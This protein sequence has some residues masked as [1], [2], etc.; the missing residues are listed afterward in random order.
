MQNTPTPPVSIADVDATR[1]L[2]RHRIAPHFM[3]HPEERVLALADK[4]L[5]EWATSLPQSSAEKIRERRYLVTWLRQR[6]YREGSIREAVRRMI[7]D[8]CRMRYHP[9]HPPA[10]EPRATLHRMMFI[11]GGEFPSDRTLR[12]DLKGSG[13]S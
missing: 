2:L 6:H 12:D 10:T 3:G 13:Q 1:A 9:A 11:S 5:A 4:L 7:A 8:A